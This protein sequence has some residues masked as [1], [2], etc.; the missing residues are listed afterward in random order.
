VRALKVQQIFKAIPVGE[1]GFFDGHLFFLKIKTAAP[2]AVI[3]T[4]AAIAA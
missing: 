2:A 4:V 1:R 3:L